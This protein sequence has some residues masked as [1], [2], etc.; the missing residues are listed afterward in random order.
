MPLR[1][2]N[3][4][5]IHRKLFAGETETIT[6]LKRDNDQ[7][8]GVVR[9]IILRHCRRS[10]VYKQSQP[11]QGEMSAQEYAT[12]HLASEDLR[13]AGVNYINVLDRIVDGQNRFWQPE[14]NVPITVKLFEN[15]VDIMTWRVDPPSPPAAAATTTI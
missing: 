1:K 14:S 2:N 12:W 7:R 11:I 6:L 8:E 13:K 9:A 4:R 3:T 15:E 10:I 5:D